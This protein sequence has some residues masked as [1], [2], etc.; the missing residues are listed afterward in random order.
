MV[1]LSFELGAE[2]FLFIHYSISMST[3]TVSVQP[4]DTKDQQTKEQ[5][6]GQ[7]MAIRAREARE[8][9]ILQITAE[10][11]TV[12]PVLLRKV[13]A[14]ASKGRT[15]VRIP[16][17]ELPKNLRAT[18]LLESRLEREGLEVQR[19]LDDSYT[20]HLPEPRKEVGSKLLPV[21]KRK[22]VVDLTT[23]WAKE[24]EDLIENCEKAKPKTAAARMNGGAQSL[25]D[26][27]MSPEF[28]TLSR[29]NLREIQ[30]NHFQRTANDTYS[31]ELVN[32]GV[33]KAF[34]ERCQQLGKDF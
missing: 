18:S 30:I 20:I 12:V 27:I 22:V 5:T 16:E 4:V 10:L 28:E 34:T 6:F 31:K 3:E 23:E 24:K 13:E 9:E 21:K 17:E 19:E 1:T 7:R 33:H 26:L 32:L 15:A 11:E 25:L 8:K 2:T 29:E 14:A